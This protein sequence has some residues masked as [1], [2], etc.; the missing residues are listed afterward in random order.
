MSH[1]FTT[2]SQIEEL[3]TLTKEEW[4]QAVH[5]QFVDELFAGTLSD[6]VLARYLIQDYQFFEAF[7]SMLGAC[8]AHASSLSAKLRFAR[9]LG[10]WR[11][12]RT[13]TL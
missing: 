13:A 8:V 1:A 10:F 7:L 2:G 6:E 3:L 5:H 9:Q 11:Q 12:M 4:H